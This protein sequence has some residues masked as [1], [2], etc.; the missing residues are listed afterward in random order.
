[1]AK[2]KL[3]DIAAIMKHIDICMLATTG[4]RGV[5]ESRPMSNN[6]DVEYNG[7]SY[8]FTDRK[9]AVVREITKDNNVNLSFIGH[10][11]I[12]NRTSVY[13]SVI[14]KAKLITD[15]EVMHKHWTKDLDL[16]FKNG[17]QTKGLTMI[18]VKA[19]TIRY[20]DG[21]NEGVIEAK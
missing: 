1:M 11:S 12:L 9:N 14:G 8:F 18:A 21:M 6:R 17:I 20:W 16:W 5:L 10:H 3:K 7:N 2:L 19:K 4:P 15:K 13:L